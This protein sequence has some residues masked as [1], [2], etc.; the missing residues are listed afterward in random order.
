MTD[1]R[2]T[3]GGARKQGTAHA[4]R[5]GHSPAQKG[6]PEQDSVRPRSHRRSGSEFFGPEPPSDDDGLQL[7]LRIEIPIDNLANIGSDEE[8]AYAEANQLDRILVG[9]L[10][11]LVEYLY[12]VAEEGNFLPPYRLS[13]FARP[14]GQA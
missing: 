12:A 14:V 3:P 11:E 6:Q 4:P 13:M 8:F 5:Q 7:M 1:G 10:D 2:K 9:S